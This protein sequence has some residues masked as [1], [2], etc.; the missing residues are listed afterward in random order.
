MNVLMV[1][2]LLAASVV[3]PTTP[4]LAE[5]LGERRVFLWAIALFTTAW[6]GRIHPWTQHRLVRPRAADPL[7]Q[8]VL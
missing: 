2:Y 6:I 4:R 1:S 5:R 8:L 7:L 3:I